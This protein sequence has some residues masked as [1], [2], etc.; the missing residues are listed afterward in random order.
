MSMAQDNELFDLDA[1]QAQI[2]LSMSLTEQL[3]SS[4]MTTSSKVSNE[5]TS[6]PNHGA[7]AGSGG[8]SKQQAYD[9]VE[10][11]LEEYLRRPPR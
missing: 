3:V 9:K 4:W 10:R 6:Q 11:D 7:R 2:D 5:S 8:V 1:L